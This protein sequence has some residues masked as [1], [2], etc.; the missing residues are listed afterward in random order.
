MDALLFVVSFAA[1]VA[2]IFGLILVYE[3][4]ERPSRTLGYWL[5][6]KLRITLRGH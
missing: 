4:L 5:E 6:E 1:C 2:A 3:I